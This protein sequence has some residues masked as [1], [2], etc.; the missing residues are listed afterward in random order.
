[1]MFLKLQNVGRV[2]AHQ[3]GITLSIHEQYTR[4]SWSSQAGK[5]QRTQF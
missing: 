2:V 3:I 4:F 1:L 5:T